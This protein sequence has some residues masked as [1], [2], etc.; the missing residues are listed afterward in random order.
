MNENYIKINLNGDYNISYLG[1]EAY[2]G[3]REPDLTGFLI[4]N[5]VPA[6]LEDLTEE[7]AKADFFNALNINPLYTEQRYPQTGYV[8][9]MA[10]PNYV[11]TFVYKRTFDFSLCEGAVCLYVGGIQNAL[12]CWI[13]GVYVGRH[14]GYSS[15]F[16]L[17]IPEGII[18][19]GSNNITLAVSNSRLSGYMER[20]IFG[21]T[22]RAANE[23][24]GG[25]YGD[26]E[27]RIYKNA[28]RDVWST[29]SEDLKYFSIN[30]DSPAEIDYDV[31]ILSG[32]VRKKAT[33]IKRGEKSVLISTDGLE[34]WSPENPTRY[35]ATVNM[36]G[37][38]V[39]LDFGIRK[40]A[41]KGKKL[42][43]NGKPFYARGICEHGYYP[44]TVHPPRDVSYYKAVIKKIKS[45]GFNLIRF[46]TT[47]P[48]PEYIAAAD[49]LG[50]LMEIE[51][52][53][54]TTYNE[55]C[56]II[57][58]THS[59]TAPVIY[60]SGN[61]MVID[62]E[63]IEHLRACAELVHTK[64]DSLFSPM[65]AMRGIEYHSYGD[66]E[67]DTPFPHNP[68]RLAALNE[69]CDLYNTYSLG[70]LSYESETADPELIDYRNTIYTRP[71][72][73]HEICI[74]G[75]YCDL[76]LKERYEG[77]RIGKTAFMSS[78]EE[79]LTDKGLIDRADVF[80]KNSSEWQRRLRK[81]CFE[82]ARRCES[83]AGYDFLGD[84]DHHWHTFGYCVG[85]MNEFYEL[86]P[87]E[88]QENVLRYNNDAVILADLPHSVNFCAEKSV[89]I[90]IHISNFGEDINNAVLEVCISDESCT[91][92]TERVDIAHISSDG[93]SAL[94]NVSF[95]APKTSVPLAVKLAA[96]LS[97][98]K[99]T[100]D[101]EW[102]MYVFPEVEELGTK[103]NGLT[104][105]DDVSASE[106][107]SKMEA[108]ESVL[109]FGVGPFSSGDTSFQIALAG[110]TTGHLA[111]LIRESEITSAF[112]HSGF[113]SW[114]F[115]DMLNGG[116]SVVLDSPEIP[117]TPIIEIASTYKNA[118]REA[119][120]FEYR[121]GAGKL[122]VCSLNLPENDFGARY[123]KKLIL[124]YTASDKFMPE[125]FL[126]VDQ[127]KTLCKD[128]LSIS[129]R[130][131]NVAQNA[132][133]ITM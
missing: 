58:Y 80:Y 107:I 71:L 30:I 52:P 40:L 63:Y 38:S 75:T 32:I 124:N 92:L 73:S 14:E 102:E 129:T 34:F 67:V 85:M 130:N 21:C 41:R 98:E 43:L 128:K 36:S 111:T 81:A 28:V 118:R 42:Y 123:L 59:Y 37:A 110:R 82:A 95:T 1:S 133:D 125:E 86:K 96:K 22:S 103:K 18:K 45:L 12:S 77:T 23:C 64:T 88:T 7:F 6:Y 76:S 106:L 89:D 100:L 46:H 79:H 132:N 72:L 131:E 122:F 39:A 99:L 87:S 51:T 115:R 50:I 31:E 35:T 8:A 9:D 20:P 114:Q 55:W 3:T 83:I 90:P 49:E 56:D 60:S 19:D 126:S 61:E 57:A 68:K 117:F 97:S 91:Y 93:T 94:Y 65:S 24:T 113:C 104:V 13:N 66:F 47:V 11:G 101:N 108:G 25:I 5:A 120:M 62:E 70:L 10:L 105:T 53:N 69:F 44:I 26:V 27:I 109:L 127:L 15:S 74:N 17:D 33:T 54:N 16:M 29:T 4:K 2:S 84:I 119:L 116:K 121:I 78:V 112:V 48:M